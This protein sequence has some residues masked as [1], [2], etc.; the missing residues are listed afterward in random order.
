MVFSENK[1]ENFK[2]TIPSKIV[3]TEPIVQ[4]VIYV[5]F[6]GF[7]IYDKEDYKKLKIARVYSAM[8][9]IAQKT[10]QPIEKVIDDFCKK[11]KRQL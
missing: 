1:F 5:D 6:L 4:T 11:E 9:K 2:K 8:E 3:S 10:S 7:N